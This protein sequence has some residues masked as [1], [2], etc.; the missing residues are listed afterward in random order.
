MDVSR[1]GERTLHTRERHAWADG[2]EIV[3][4]SYSTGDLDQ[5]STAMIVFV[6]CAHGRTYSLDVVPPLREG[7]RLTVTRLEPPP[8]WYGVSSQRRKPPSTTM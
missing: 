4:G 3:D 6:A 2:W 7:T 8:D 5:D 1:S